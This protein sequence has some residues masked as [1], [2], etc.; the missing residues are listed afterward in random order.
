MKQFVVEMNY[1]LNVNVSVK[2]GSKEEAI[3]RAKKMVENNIIVE[4]SRHLDR[5]ESIH[6]SEL[7]FEEVTF[8]SEKKN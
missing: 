5:A 8:V 6:P 2:A 7:I 1:A 3:E 4:D